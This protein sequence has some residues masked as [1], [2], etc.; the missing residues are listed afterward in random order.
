MNF[1]RK[2]R[3]SFFLL[4]PAIIVIFVFAVAAQSGSGGSVRQEGKSNQRP[5]TRPAQTPTPQP[6]ITEDPEMTA[7]EIADIIRVETGLVTVPVR[8][9][10]RKNRFIGGLQQGDF[11][12]YENGVEQDIAH[13]SNESQP[14]TVALVLD[15]SYSATFKI[16]DIQLAAIDFINQLRPEDRVTVI[17][18]DEEVH[19]LCPVT[20]DRKEIFRAIKQTKIS[21]GTSLYEAVDISVNQMLRDVEGR[22]AMVLF[23]DGVDTTSRSAYDR[24]NLNDVLELD[25]LI[26]PIR[27]DTFADV[28]SLKNRTII[29]PP[30]GTSLPTP[31]TFPKPG[32]L[33]IPVESLPTIG[34]PDS[35]GT[36]EAEYAHAEE[37]L[38][39]LA[40]RT[41]G[42]MYLATTFGN[43]NSAFARIASELREF[44]SIG[45]YPLEM[46]KPGSTL[47]LKV[48]VDRPGTA[49][50]AKN[51]YIVP[52]RETEKSRN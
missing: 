43:L 16:A 40:E 12:V 27:Y 11:R 9:M 46:A 13:F 39:Q 19:V 51:R 30:T 33:P 25:I 28:Q 29:R 14:F 42:R 5:N 31:T 26:Y 34:T 7:E 4:I 1:A 49:V 38:D 44:Y 47:K 21:T 8:V 48:Q 32:G 24:D 6:E 45:Y 18:F 37:Y 3:I 22:K 35:K 36:T 20:N 50:R 2:T 10:D 41:G 52:D 23:T 15:M 17:S